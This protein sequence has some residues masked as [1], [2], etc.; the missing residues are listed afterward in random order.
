MKNKK[1]TLLLSAL[2]FSLL[3][4]SCAANPAADAGNLTT[5][6]EPKSAETEPSEE[7]AEEPPLRTES[8]E[9]SSQKTDIADTEEHQTSSQPDAPFALE[10]SETHSQTEAVSAD[11]VKNTITIIPLPPSDVEKGGYPNI[12]YNGKRYSAEPMTGFFTIDR[13][14]NVSVTATGATQWEGDYTVEAAMLEFKSLEY[15][16]TVEGSSDGSLDGAE[17]YLY[18]G[19]KLIF[20]GHRTPDLSDIFPLL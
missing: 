5:A 11:G 20:T 13:S 17:A 7:T 16:G 3:L 6:S 9:E 8:P 10:I 18:G 12:E 15:L 1:L 14:G 2:T 19:D 4:T